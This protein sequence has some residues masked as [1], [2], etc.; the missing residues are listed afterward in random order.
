MLYSGLERNPPPR[1][2]AGEGGGSVAPVLPVVLH[3]RTNLGLRPTGVE[4]LGATLLELGLADR[5]RAAVVPPIE[6]PSYDEVLDPDVGAYNVDAV[7]RLAIEQAGRVDAIVEARNFPLVLGGDDTVLFGCGLALRRLGP[8]GLMLI[9]GH[10]DF[11]DV[12]HGSGELS[13]SDLWLATGRGSTPLSDLEGR[14]PLFDDRCCVVYGHRDRDQ[15]RAGGSDDVYET[16]MLVRNLAELRAAGM[17]A[18]GAHAVAF[19]AASGAERVWLHLDA[20]CLDDEVMSAVDW[21]L[22]GGLRADEVIELAGPLLSSGLLAGMDVTIYNPALDTPE[23]AAGRVL[24]DLVAAL[25]DAACRSEG[26]STGPR[27]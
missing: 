13:D 3:V 11:F 23:R 1:G 6:A 18:A 15:Q 21:R 24:T 14:G 25:V 4:D 7:A 5:L 16:P 12:Q 8:A 9:D 22:P 10:T 27:P 17:R 20:D 19:L 26:R 2:R